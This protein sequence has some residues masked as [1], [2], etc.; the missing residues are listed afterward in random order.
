MANPNDILGMNARERLYRTLNKSQ[1]K[2]Y[3]NSKLELKR[4]M[5]SNT[6]PTPKLYARF[7]SMDEVYDFN[8]SEISTSFVV[9]PIGGNG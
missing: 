9:K 1:G 8:F 4:L 3:A 2:K 6:I 5:E 7:A